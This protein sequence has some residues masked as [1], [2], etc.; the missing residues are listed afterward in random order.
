MDEIQQQAGGV[1]YAPS[2]P[3]EFCGRREELERIYAVLL[4]VGE[5]GQTVMISGPP[6]IGKS[7][8]LN[9][10]AYEVQERPGGW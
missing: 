3:E 8:L 4:A 6:G 7:S 1:S 5:H 2:S 10:L 9:R